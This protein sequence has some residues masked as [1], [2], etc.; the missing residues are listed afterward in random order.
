MTQTDAAAAQVSPPSHSRGGRPLVLLAFAGF[1]AVTLEMLPTGLLPAMTQDLQVRP[2]RV[3]LLVT[4]W[5][6]TIG[7][8]S[9][10]LAR[11]TRRCS[12]PGVLGGSLAVVGVAALATALAP[13]YGAVLGARVV[14]AVGHGLFWAVLLDYAAS[15]VPARRQ[16]RA[17]AVVQAGPLLAGAVGLPVATALR[18]VVGWRIVMAAVAVI[19]AV[20]GVV[21]LTALPVSATSSAGARPALRRDPTALPVVVTAVLG[22]LALLAHFAAFTYVAPLATRQWGLTDGSVSPLLLAFGVFSVLGLAAAGLIGDRHPRASLVAAITGMAAIL[23]VL[24]IPAP[25][26]AATIAGVAVWGGFLGMLPPLLQ[27][28]VL[29]TA[30]SQYRS[31]AGAVI[32]ATFNLGIASGAAAGGLVIDYVDLSRLL[33]F[34]A[35]VALLS[36]SGLGA[37]LANR[38]REGRRA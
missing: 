33:P 24:A 13:S 6:M 15:I 7:L 8:S 21:L 28:V 30:S 17:L 26:A 34:A 20:L 3:G 18:E 4:A 5:A 38:A 32:V 22:A 10:P 1:W 11:G 9:I 2:S 23:A 27:N 35:G 16:A 25:P 36:A 31:T 37:V 12:R 29:G 19:L 14:A